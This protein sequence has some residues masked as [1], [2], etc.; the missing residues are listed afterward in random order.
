VLEP[1]VLYCRPNADILQ[2]AR[3]DF[4]AALFEILDK[5]EQ[6]RLHYEDKFLVLAELTKNPFAS[7]Y[8]FNLKPNH[9]RA[10][11]SAL[12]SC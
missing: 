1:F 12:D 8:P 3:S 6:E 7:L 10:I 2:E 5:L 4:E 9:V 11:V